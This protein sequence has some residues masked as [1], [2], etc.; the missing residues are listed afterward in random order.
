M[1]FNY[2]Y[3][4]PNVTGIFPDK[5]T[6]VKK[7]DETQITNYRYTSLLR[8][9]SKIFERIIFKQLYQR[10][11]HRMMVSLVI[12]LF[13]INYFMIVSMD[14]KKVSQLNILH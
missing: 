13:I 3:N 11:H 10:Y 8:T 4:Y 12:S 5:L 9:R 1:K 14:S 6:T 2:N 7:D